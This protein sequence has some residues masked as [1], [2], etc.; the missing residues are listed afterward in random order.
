MIQARRVA[1]IDQVRT[2][3]GTGVA[4]PLFMAEGLPAKGY[5]VTF[6]H[7]TLLHQHERSYAFVDHHPVGL[8]QRFCEQER[9]SAAIVAK[10]SEDEEKNNHCSSGIMHHELTLKTIISLAWHCLSQL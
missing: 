6:Y 5:L 8:G 4:L 10:T 9:I 3:G 7:F 1:P 2:F